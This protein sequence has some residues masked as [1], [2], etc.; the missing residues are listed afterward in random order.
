MMALTAAPSGPLASPPFLSE[1]RRFF[2]AVL[3]EA[4]G[5]TPG[6]PRDAILG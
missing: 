5:R 3:K 4:A 1:Q 6:W 2:T